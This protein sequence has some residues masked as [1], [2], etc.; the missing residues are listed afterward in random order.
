MT[1]S[2]LLRVVCA[3]SLIILVMGCREKPADVSI[4]DTAFAPRPGVAVSDTTTNG[5]YPDREVVFECEKAEFANWLAASQGYFEVN[6]RDF[7]EADV[8]RNGVLEVIDQK[9][10]WCW[11]SGTLVRDGSYGIEIVTENLSAGRVR[12]KIHVSTL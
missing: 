9:K 4:V 7:D 2:A 6:G 5:K 1:I 3:S 11:A 8:I 12:A 10:E